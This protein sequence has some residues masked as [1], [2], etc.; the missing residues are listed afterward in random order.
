M[1][2]S[3]SAGT[4]TGGSPPGSPREKTR[5]AVEVADNNLDQ[6]GLTAT[7]WFDSGGPGQP[8]SKRVRFSG[9]RLGITG[10]PH[11]RDSFVK[12]ETIDG[13]VPASGPVSVTTRVSG[14]NPGE[15]TITAELVSPQGVSRKMRSQMRSGH[16]DKRSLSPAVWSWR[17][18]ALSTGSASPVKTRWALLTAFDRM[19]AVVPGSYTGLVVLG[20]VIGLVLQALLLAHDHVDVGRVLTASLL[21]VA[22]GLVGAK[23]WYLALHPREW[24]EAIRLGW[25]IQGFLVGVAV[26]TTLS[27][28]ILHLPIGVVLDATAPGLFVGLAI[29]RIGCFFT[30]CCAGRPSAS[31]WAIWSS[32]ARVGARRVPTQ[33]LE[34]F[35]AL[36]IGL[37]ALFVILQY[38]AGVPGAL[39]V[40]S[41]ATYTLCRQF[42]LAFRAERRK[43]SIGGPLTGAGAALVLAAAVVISVVGVRLR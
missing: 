3:R 32:D 12:E 33:L 9:R 4:A 29:G 13:I 6:H 41:F 8:Y 17:R 20:I 7:F 18:W 30:G 24:R 28:G 38:R 2:A 1:R 16:R 15:W 22:L 23:L 10:R 14:I 36:V 11:S 43:S 31:R 37:L 19:P 21:A 34:S 5:P 27:L 39:F 40:A 35:A 25:C 42:L 26:V